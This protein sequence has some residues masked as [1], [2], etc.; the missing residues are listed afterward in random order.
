M[1]GGFESY[2]LRLFSE[3]KKK[4]QQEEDTVTSNEILR[5]EKVMRK[6]MRESEVV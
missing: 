3:P 2:Q 1:L 6:Y 5:I 4:K